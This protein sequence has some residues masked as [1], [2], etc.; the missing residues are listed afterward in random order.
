[1]NSWNNFLILGEEEQARFLLDISFSAWNLVENLH[2]I[3]SKVTDYLEL[4]YEILDGDTSKWSV[5]VKFLDDPD[6][7]EDFPAYCEL[8]KDD[9]IASAALDLAS[10]AC[11][12]VCRITA[13]RVGT[14][15]L[16]DPVIES[17]PEVY[18]YFRD[19]AESI[20]VTI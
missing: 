3:K 6:M 1:M 5:L 13:A 10:Y 12:F 4:G 17:L 19:R 15:S 16:P 14:K 20:G 8:T 11:G 9:R 18:E 7:K 2:E